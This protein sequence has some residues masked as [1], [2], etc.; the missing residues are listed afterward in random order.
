M[1]RLP[2]KE[3]NK[4]DIA[5]A[6]GTIA[7]AYGWTFS[8]TWILVLNGPF[9]T[10]T[11]ACKNPDDKFKWEPSVYG[12]IFYSQAF[13]QYMVALGL[14]IALIS[15]II[16][17]TNSSSSQRKERSNVSSHYNIYKISTDT[18]ELP[19]LVLTDNTS[20]LTAISL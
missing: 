9:F 19:V 8:W 1:F 18:S 16:K 4:L 10:F 17:T 14:N 5:K 11:R 12:A 20:L 15:K 2:T 3:T 6:G 13:F 7:G